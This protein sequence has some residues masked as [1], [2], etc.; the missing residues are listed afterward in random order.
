MP[1][2]SLFL[3][4]G[5]LI[6]S[7]CMSATAS[8][9]NTHQIPV[10]ETPKGEILLYLYD[11]TPEHKANFLK[12]AG[13]GF[14]DGTTFHRVIPQFMIQGGDPNSKDDDPTNDGQGG[15]GYTQAAEIVEGLRHKRGALAAAR[16]GDQVNPEKRSSGSQ[17]YIVQ[18]GKLTPQE[19]QQMEMQQNQMRLNE[20]AG[21]WAER[22][23][24]SWIKETDIRSMMQTDPDSAQKLIQRFNQEVQTAF[25]EEAEPFSYS[26][27]EREA[28]MEQGG[29]PH[30]DGGY[31]VFGEVIIGMNVVD[32]IVEVKADGNDRPLEDIPMTV[33]IQE[34]TTEELK[35]KYGFEI[36]AFDVK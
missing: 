34:L 19:V 12:L 4:R 10:I 14:Y 30:L 11:V 28:L 24:N 9:Q 13:E 7:F 6:L 22:P 29:T 18:R 31:T 26:Q 8:A 36:P 3:L 2:F 33:T 32:A 35:K 15:P 23:E 21:K 20:F 25:L 16:L 27:E 5:L 17:F 1:D